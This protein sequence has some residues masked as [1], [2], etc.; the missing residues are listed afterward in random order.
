MTSDRTPPRPRPDASRL[1]IARPKA[2]ARPPV[3]R[4]TTTDEPA[5]GPAV[6]SAPLDQDTRPGRIAHSSPGLVAMPPV[7][8]PATPK[9][10]GSPAPPV[11]LR[12]AAL[13]GFAAAVTV[14]LDR[15]G[16]GWLLAGLACA[17]VVFAVL[18][19]K[20]TAASGA[21]RFVRPGWTLLALALLS[22]GT[23]RTAG[24]LFVLCVLGAAVAGSFAVTDPRSVRDL[25]ADS[26]AVPMSALVSLPWLR[27]GVTSLRGRSG[28][29]QVRLLVSVLV[30]VLLV[31][32]FG[33]LF[34][35]ADATFARIVSGALPSVRGGSA[36]QWLLVFVLAAL[37]AAGACRLVLAPDVDPNT[38]T[39]R[40]Q[41]SV[42]VRRIEW[43]VPVALLVALFAAFVADQVAVLF[44]GAGYVLRTADLT[45]AQYAR[46]GFWQLSVVTVLTLAVIVAAT[47]VAARTTRADRAWLRGLLGSLAVL[48]LVIVASALDRMW[49]YQ[50]AYGF[51]V[52]R[53]L[54]ESAEVWMGVVYVLVIAAGLHMTG[55]WLPRAVAASGLVALLVLGLLDPERMVA[56]ENVVRWQQTGRIDRFYLSELSQDAV[57]ALAP[58]P[59]SLRGCVLRAMAN[60]VG[61]DTDDWREWNAARSS[62]ARALAETHPVN[63]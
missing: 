25:L 24:W 52:Q 41:R 63:C 33:A 14:P 21:A 19:G 31:I 55:R 6:G 16:I 50:R 17:A 30:G 12:A 26:V 49:S 29:R 20:V 13:A 42:T 3:S 48:T 5:S 61:S 2:E 22:I 44:G 1:G 51:T 9:P 59:D 34:A 60:R 11:V 37:G 7:W 28:G 4:T 47:R 40:E 46:S 32:V 58:L 18:R 43:V 39:A 8:Q 62:A 35:G 45:Y 56:G 54:V 38:A 27:R 57:P 15:P 10:A 23:Y 36:F 53:L